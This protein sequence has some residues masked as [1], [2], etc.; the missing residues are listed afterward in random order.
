MSALRIISLVLVAS[1]AVAAAGD[2]D[3]AV[4]LTCK[5]EQAHDCLP[6][7]AA[8]APVKRESKIDPVFGID[9]AKKEVRSPWRTA[10]LPVQ[11]TTTKP[12]KIVLQ[13]VDP[14]GTVAWSALVDRKTGALTVSIADRTGSYVAFGQC[15]VA[16]AK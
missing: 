5:V 13:G 8:C 11:H 2:F 4:P 1:S 16:V 9:F 10:V 6:T 15:T 7:K 14:D 12:E 3:G